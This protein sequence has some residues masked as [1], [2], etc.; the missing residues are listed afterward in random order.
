MSGAHQQ[1]AWA[2]SEAPAP[3][4]KMPSGPTVNL[5]AVSATL[6][7]SATPLPGSGAHTP[8]G[9]Y[10]TSSSP[11]ARGSSTHSSPNISRT[12]SGASEGSLG[13]AAA[14][15]AGA[16][17]LP[18]PLGRQSSGEHSIEAALQGLAISGAASPAAPPRLNF[19]APPSGALPQ[20]APV[21]VFAKFPQEQS[22]GPSGRGAHAGGRGGGHHGAAAAYAAPHSGGYPSA[23]LAM[24][25]PHQGGAFFVESPPGGYPPHGGAQAHMFGGPA[26]HGGQGGTPAA[27]A[28]FPAAAYY[29]QHVGHAGGSG[30]HPGA[31]YMV[32]HPYYGMVPAGHYG[33]TPYSMYPGPPPPHSAPAASKAAYEAAA[34]EYQARQY[35]AMMQYQAMQGFGMMVSPSGSPE[36]GGG[37]PLSA[38]VFRRNNSGQ[39]RDDVRS[40]RSSGGRPSRLSLDMSASKSENGD[41]HRLDPAL[42]PLVAEDGS[43]RQSQL[44]DEYKATREARAWTLQELQGHLYPFCRDQHGSRLVQQQLEGADPALVSELF[45]EVRH[46]LLPLMVDVFGNYVVQRFLERG[47]PEVHAAVA[48][49]M[50]GKVL[51]LALQMYG[52][53][54]VQKAL[55]VFP[56]E[57]RVSIVGELSGHT[58]RCVRDQNG[59]HVVQKCIECVQPSEPARPMIEAI[60]AKVQPLSTHTFGCRLVQRV[61]EHC[62]IPE[63]RE[64]VIAEV[65]GNALQLSHDQYGNYVV[66]HLVTKG[67]A[68]ARDAIVAKAAPQ[69]MTLAQH[70]YASNVVEACLKRGEQRHR[71]A[72]IEQMIADARARPT[73]LTAL[74][75]DQYGNYVVQRGLEVATPPQRA[76]LLAVIQPHL[77]TLRK[78]AYGKHIAAKAEALLAAQAAAAAEPASAPEPAAP[79]QGGA[80]HEH[81]HHCTMP[82]RRG[83]LMRRRGARLGILGGFALLAYTLWSVRSPTQHGSSSSDRGSSSVLTS[84]GTAPKYSLPDGERAD[85]IMS[86]S[87]QHGRVTKAGPLPADFWTNEKRAWREAEFQKMVERDTAQPHL[88]DYWAADASGQLALKPFPLPFPLCHTY[89]NHKYKVIFIIHPKSAS[90]ATKRYMTLCRL[91]QTDSCL[92]PLE[93][94]EQLTPL[95]QQWEEYFVFT[96]V[97]NPWARAYSSWKFLRDGYMLPAGKGPKQGDGAPCAPG[98]WRD[99]CRDP[100]LLGRMCNTQPHCCP[101]KEEAHFMYYHITD[102]GTCLEAEGGGLAVDFIGRVENVDEDMQEAVG[103]INSRLPAG[104]PPLQLPDEVAAINVGP[105]HQKE[106]P[107]DNSRYL[108]AYEGANATCFSLIARFHEK[109][110]RIMFSSLHQA[111]E[112]AEAAAVRAAV[113]R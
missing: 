16:T 72:I 76:A 15:P 74:M 64:R 41:A 36:R 18:L 38:P 30:Q 44:L 66:Q 86:G 92:E 13:G 62:S 20:A 99:F 56:M 93:R 70:K 97:R 51:P 1:S 59:N 35:Q 9:G 73:A 55:E 91:N 40:I 112:A 2:P 107:P 95:A 58:L 102:Q 5:S 54:V 29:S 34:A 87:Q 19:T 77:D 67:P 47:G 103:I 21:E 104:V 106:K 25:P 37:R 22:A 109:D 33:Q 89:V 60:V 81:W 3:G 7:G 23:S 43:E 79:E 96:F 100:L 61:L 105:K 63:L 42:E 111:A 6:A 26:P 83:P 50:R 57:E 12:G 28:G 101:G 80:L 78:Y 8:G 10:S 53:R 71:D 69:V 82:P 94:A 27:S 84:G 88:P 14:T 90:T 108:P 65:L 45:G 75:R 17:P 85:A 113:T 31:P 32:P 49:A 68:D 24:S 110:V 4:M 39:G 11:Y 98:G 48:E 52:C 46:K